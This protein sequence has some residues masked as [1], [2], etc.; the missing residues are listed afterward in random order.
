MGRKAKLV[1]DYKKHPRGHAYAKYRGKF[2]CFGKWGT[3]ESRDRY[4]AFLE[5]ISRKAFMPDLPPLGPMATRTVVVLI[6]HYVAHCESYYV[7]QDKKP[8]SELRNM[9]GLLEKHVYAVM[10]REK[11]VDIGPMMLNKLADRLVAADWCRNEVNKAINRT[12]RMF[13]WCS[14]NE[15]CPPETFHRLTCVGALPAGRGLARESADVQPVPWEVV[16]ATLPWMNVVAADMVRIQLLCAMRPEEVCRMRADRIDRSGDIW[17]YE[18]EKHKNS[19]RG[20]DRPIGIPKVAQAILRPYIE[21]LGPGEYL[22][23][24]RDSERRRRDAAASKESQ[25]RKTKVYPSELRRRSKEKL[26]RRETAFTRLRRRYDPDSYRRAISYGIKKAKRHGT[27]IESWNPYRLRHLALTELTGEC[28]I[29]TAADLAGHRSPDTT[30][31]YAKRR[32]KDVIEAAKSVDRYLAN[33][34][35]ANPSEQE[36]PATSNDAK[37]G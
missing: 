15:I 14:K 4:A 11:V 31:I 37:A 8:T 28:G 20:H 18:P 21:R 30:A 9:K 3:Q 13:R 19:W 27:E 6:A 16:D 32:L 5:D 2:Y 24:P 33:R 7:D 25:T 22:F 36:P 26:L 34:P 23:S 12:K 1:P 17:I 10:G 35:S 29:D